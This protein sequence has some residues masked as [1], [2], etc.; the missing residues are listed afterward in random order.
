MACFIWTR[1]N[2]EHISEHG[3]TVTEAEHLVEQ[4]S[5][6][7]PEPIGADKWLVRGQTA[8]GRYIQA[9]FVLESAARG[10]HWSEVDLAAMDPREEGV[11]VIHA[12]PITDAE[13]R[14]YRRRSRK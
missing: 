10:I 9:I 14:E 13:K 12:R 6:P 11:F 2:L 5:A 1:R 7:Y 4:A 3:I 8:A